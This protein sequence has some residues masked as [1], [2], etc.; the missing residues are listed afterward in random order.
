ME[1]ALII[2][3]GLTMLYMAATSRIMAHIRILVAQGIL[4]FLICYFGIEKTSILNCIFLAFETLIVKACV[5]PMFLN[6]I[7]KTTHQYRDAEANIPHFYCLFISTVILFSGF[8]I[9]DVNFPAM[10]MITPVYLGVS[11]AVIIISLLL[12]TIKHKI[13]TNIVE[14]ITMENGIFLL[15]LAVVKEMPIIVNLGVLLDLFIAVFILGLLVNRINKEFE[16]LEVSHLSD[17]KDCEYDD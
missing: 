10:K 6:K 9:S 8:L 15:S 3:F 2:L 5:I 7:V 12:I 11:I 16:G 17:L 14:F 1:N 4:L 13:I